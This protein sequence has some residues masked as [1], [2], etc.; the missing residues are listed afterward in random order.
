MLAADTR[1]LLSGTKLLL[2]IVS[3]DTGCMHR[4]F[5][6]FASC[7]FL[8]P[9]CRWTYTQSLTP[10]GAIDVSKNPDAGGTAAML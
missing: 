10:C 2:N 8:G 1:P 4:V 9:R 6:T 5:A 7:P 3:H